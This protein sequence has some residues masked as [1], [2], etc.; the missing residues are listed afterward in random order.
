[1]ERDRILSIMYEMAQ[2]I[3]GEVS[4][5]PLLTKTLQH[6]L[7]NTSFPSG[8]VCLGA[9]FAA[10][11]ADGMI[12]VAM[13]AV[14]G[15][16]ELVGLVGS[17]VRLP[18]RLLLGAAEL[19][20]DAALMA[21]LPCKNNAY[22]GYLR[23]PVEGQGVVILL[24][25]KL[26]DTDLPFVQLFRPVMENLARAIMLC[27]NNDTY[28]GSLIAARDASQ[29]ALATSEGKF[30]AISA[31]VLDALIMLDDSGAVEYWNPAA[32]RILGYRG[33]EVIGKNMHDL[34]APQ[35]YR[36]QAALG[37]ATFRESGQGAVIGKTIEIEA[38][39]KDGRI[40]PVELS[41][42]AFNLDGRWH[43]V[44]I[45][46]DIS[47]LKRAE[48]IRTRLAAIVESSNDAI[49]GKDLNGIITS[50][51]K[52]AEKIYGYS[53][54]EIIGKSITVL[55]PP[56]RHAEIEGFLEKIRRGETVVNY[57]SNRIRKDGTWIYVALTLSPIRDAAGKISGISTIARDIT[58]RKNAEF[59]LRQSE[60]AL[61]EAQRLAHVGS[62]HMDLATNQV[63]WSE[64]LYKMYGF[65]PSLP[66]PLYTE[67]MKLFTPESWEKLS[68]AITRATETGIPYE[69]ELEMVPK[70]GGL[71]WML[72][73]GELVRDERG[74]PVRVRGV[75]MDITERKRA[76]KEINALNRELEQRVLVR[77]A[78]LE[79]A[80][81]ELE[82]FSFSVSHDLRTPLRA[83]DGF[84]QI[85]LEDYESKLDAEGC[86]L[87]HVVRDNTRKMG[88]LIDDILRFS[89]AGRVELSFVEID[90]E[91]LAREVYAE[92]LPADAGNLQMEIAALPPALGDR[93]MM[94]QVFANLLTNAIKFSR[95]SE[96]PK[97]EI[98]T[99]AEGNETVYFVRDNGVG[100]EMQ[101]ADKLFG[102]FQRL[103]SVDEFEGTGIGLAIVKRIITRHGG[104]VWAEGK[105][106]EGASMY[107]SLPQ[108]GKVQREGS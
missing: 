27:R 1:M 31:A 29:Q 59:V 82:A 62:W 22:K 18:A 19:R 26:P 25:S 17:K 23:L 76:E 49:I 64:V 51:N 103:H 66:P 104:R 47:E 81:K 46:R 71:G 102:V 36:E 98:G 48:E 105:V 34:L 33:E 8:F 96:P 35:K 92:L 80:N 13:D 94:H 90:M 21:A 56:A 11:D 85:L 79:A 20:E 15:D 40:I 86:R 99:Y 93:A 52:G 3:G 75:V 73:R 100:F 43:A 78:E 9:P 70:T 2:V 12:A 91:A 84:S 58:E 39:H 63:V 30:K 24:V 95:N 61:K 107:F 38:Q 16:Y 74:V 32:E 37:F 6:L 72:A 5:Q 41:I 89:R 7:Y 108:A 83:I 67:S 4:V 60:E 88:A 87:L 65:D 54:E 101:Y 69:L 14:V 42:S 97:V 44:G 57:E 55:A 10:A 28:T 53:A 68:S 106:G 77:T 45:L 50:W